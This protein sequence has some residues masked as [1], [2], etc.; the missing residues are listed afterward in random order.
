MA[1]Q[2]AICFSTDSFGADKSVDGSTLTV[3]L[4]PPLTIHEGPLLRRSK[5]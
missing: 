5:S 4:D 2:T 3:K 1:D